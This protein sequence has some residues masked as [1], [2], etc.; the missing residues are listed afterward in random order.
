MNATIYT[1]P[2]ADIL[3]K[4]KEIGMAQQEDRK[5]PDAEMN[6]IVKRKDKFDG[7]DTEYFKT[8]YSKAEDGND[9]SGREEQKNVKQPTIDVPEYSEDHDKL[10]VQ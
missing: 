2:K 10:R 8:I 4:L 6:R 9:M 5:G 1:T 7:T 3:K